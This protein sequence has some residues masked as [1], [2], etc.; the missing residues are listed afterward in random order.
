MRRDRRKVVSTHQIKKKRD[1]LR[2][3]ERI[4]SV[5]PKPFIKEKIRKRFRDNPL[6]LRITKKRKHA[7]ETEKQGFNHAKLLEIKTL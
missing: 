5:K 4:Q 3:D 6:K 2:I 7:T 1:A